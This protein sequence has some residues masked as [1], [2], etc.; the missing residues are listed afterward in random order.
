MPDAG[1]TTPATSLPAATMPPAVAAPVAPASNDNSALAKDGHP[2]AGWHSGLFYLRDYNDNFRLYVQGRAQIDTY[3]YFGPGVSDTS[4][5][6]TMFLRRIRPELSGEILKD[7]KFMLAGDFG[8]TSNDNTS[9]TNETFAAAAG[10]APTATSGSYAG[11]QTSHVA[12]AATDVF[13][14]YHA[15]QL[16][17]IQAGQFDAPFT[18]ENRT[19]DKYLEF[20]E[21]PLAVRVV[22]IPT[23][24]EIGG[25][26]WGET[27]D[28]FWFYSAGVFDGDGQN[29]LSPDARADFMARTFIHPLAGGSDEVLKN[30]QIGASLRYGKRDRN[31]TFYD[32]SNMT[33]QGNYTFWKSTYKSGD[34]VDTTLHVIPDGNQLGVAGELRVPI[35]MFDLQSE[36]VYINNQTREGLD[37]LEK[38]TRRSGEIKGTSYYVELGFWP[39]GNRDI[40]GLPGYENPPHV[41]FAKADAPEPKQALQLVLRW[42]QLN[43]KYESASRHGVADPSNID[44]SIKLNTLGLSANY[45]ATKHIRLTTNY[46]MNMF[47]DSEPSSSSTANG[48]KWSSSQRA[49]APG[50]TLG[51][52][53]NDSARDSAHALYELLF[54]V[55]VAF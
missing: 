36:F 45:W 43:L 20:M 53:I 4:L 27:G 38:T 42:E 19:S 52:G 34:G 24:K 37:G 7:W 29:K 2:M 55:A 40:N 18:M 31:Y 51:K 32:V 50:N 12:A 11:A 22:G 1:V 33:T 25:M 15:D 41:D 54:R 49:Q 10:S 5:K 47:P 13:L 23:N 16:L 9:G 39:L 6:P 8:A 35:D 28:K 30:L 44:G 26:L 14:I 48:P 3:T 21:R 46:I 17:N